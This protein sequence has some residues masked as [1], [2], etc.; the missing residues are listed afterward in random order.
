MKTAK[1]KQSNMTARRPNTQTTKTHRQTTTRN[2]TTSSERTPAK[3]PALQPLARQS[4][5]PSGPDR[6]GLAAVTPSDGK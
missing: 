2:Q 5:W 6:A 1:E 4:I 3:A